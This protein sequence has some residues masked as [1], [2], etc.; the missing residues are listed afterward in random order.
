M[1]IEYIDFDSGLLSM[2]LEL[3]PEDQLKKYANL[4]DRASALTEREG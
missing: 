1:Y 2:D 3:V 4:L